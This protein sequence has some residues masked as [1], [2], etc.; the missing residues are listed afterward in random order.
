MNV[1]MENG[2]KLL[3][4]EISGGSHGF[5]RPALARLPSPRPNFDNTTGGDIPIRWTTDAHTLPAVSQIYT[6]ER[7]HEF[8]TRALEQHQHFV[9][10]I[11]PHYMDLLYTFW[12]HFLPMNFNQ[13]MY[14]EFRQ[15]A[16]EDVKK[17]S[18]VGMKHLIH[19]YDQS[20]NCKEPS[21]V[22]DDIANDFVHLIEQEDSDGERRAFQTLR[23][24]WRNG[25]WSMK[26]RSKITK[27]IDKDLAAQ[28]DS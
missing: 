15:L 9:G 5:G 4:H 1:C 13:R 19:F 28:L 18:S 16:L 3:I 26:N 21:V 20:L 14:D 6:K 7:Y 23:K 27:L 17:A 25:A 12:S 10:G 22:P 11:L 2:A 24:N 8:R